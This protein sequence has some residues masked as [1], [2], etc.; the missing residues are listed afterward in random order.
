MLTQT[1]DPQTPQTLTLSQTHFPAPEKNNLLRG[2]R[3]H[4]IDRPNTIGSRLLY[5]EKAKKQIKGKK[6]S[7]TLKLKMGATRRKGKGHSQEFFGIRL[8][9]N[10]IG[11][12]FEVQKILLTYYTQMWRHHREVLDPRNELCYR[13]FTYVSPLD[14]PPYVDTDSSDD[15]DEEE[16]ERT[17]EHLLSEEL[18]NTHNMIVDIC[19]PRIAKRS[20]NHT[21]RVILSQFVS[22]FAGH[23]FKIKLYT[24]A[25]KMLCRLYALVNPDVDYY[26]DGEFTIDKIYRA[27]Y[28]DENDLTNLEKVIALLDE[29]YSGYACGIEVEG[30]QLDIPEDMRRF[31]D[32]HIWWRVDSWIQLIKDEVGDE[33]L[34]WEIYS[35]KNWKRYYFT[36]T[37][38]QLELR[39]SGFVG[40]APFIQKYY[41]E[42]SKWKL[43]IFN[44]DKVKKHKW[45]NSFSNTYTID[46]LYPFPPADDTD[47][48][49]IPEWKSYPKI[50][51]IYINPNAVIGDNNW[52]HSLMDNGV[53]ETIDPNLLII[54]DFS[55]S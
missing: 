17:T 20:P 10:R 28:W 14:F 38:A 21:S 25:I 15:S 46:E 22:S 52:F 48:E 19:R 12:P 34:L 30:K 11:I 49:E 1:P 3:T 8:C 2:C 24:P 51:D 7:M 9:L 45:F 53:E 4:L 43:Y 27:S 37:R 5:R 31:L 33:N 23:T 42:L 29:K 32:T 44:D 50:K 35:D 6:P 13:G 54:Q 18:H 40:R 55:S 47:E 39:R 26:E 41:F 36:G 16:Y